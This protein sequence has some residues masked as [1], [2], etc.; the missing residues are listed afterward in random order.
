METVDD[1]QASNSGRDIELLSDAEGAV[2]KAFDAEL[3]LVVA[4]FS[5]RKTFL[6]S[7]SGEVLA[8]WSEGK[9][10]ADVKD[11]SH[12]MEVLAA[13]DSLA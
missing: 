2:S 10:M 4:K 9:N 8:K 1:L 3:S 12:A 5:A 6:L 11:G 13:I 7:P